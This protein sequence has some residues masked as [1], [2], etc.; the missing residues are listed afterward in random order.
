MAGSRNFPCLVR[1]CRMRGKT[2]GNHRVKSLLQQNT[3][4]FLFASIA[5]KITADRGQQFQ[6]PVRRGFIV[7]PSLV[8]RVILDASP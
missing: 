7:Y 6:Q 5:K 3:D 4:H 8:R 2:G 1:D